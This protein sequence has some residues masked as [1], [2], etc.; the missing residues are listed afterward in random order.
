MAES[1]PI[2]NDNFTFGSLFIGI[3]GIDL[4][5][6][7]AGMQCAWQSEI[8]DH[9]SGVLAKHWPSV[10]NLGDITLVDWSTVERVDVICGGYPC[11]PFSLAGKRQG[12]EDERHLWPHFADAIRTLR[13]S[14][15]IMENVGGHL[16]L[17]FDTVLSDLATLGYDAEWEVVPASALGAPHARARLLVVAYPSGSGLEGRIFSE[18]PRTAQ[19]ELPRGFGRAG[20]DWPMPPQVSGV[21][22]GL[23]DWVDRI[24]ELGN[25]VV[26]ALAEWLGQLIVEAAA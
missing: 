20:T 4:G 1:S 24:R 10:P 12:T 7:R 21:G 6:E 2:E 5:L 25:A 13:P 17:G 19:H 22:Y 9:A 26:P 18:A 11:Q 3:G 23:P 15:T 8:M 14:F 16:T